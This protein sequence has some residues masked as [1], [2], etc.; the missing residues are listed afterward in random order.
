M[1]VFAHHTA[2]E[3]QERLQVERDRKAKQR[4]RAI[5]LALE[6][7]TSAAIGS[8]LG[9]RQPTVALWIRRYNE[10]GLSSLHDAVRPGRPMRLSSEQI[11]L[12]RLRLNAGP[13]PEDG[14]CTLRGLD[15]QRILEQEFGVVY[16]LNGV[17][18]LLHHLGYSSLMPRPQHCE[19]DLEAREHFKKSSSDCG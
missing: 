18:R 7:R 6:G 17:Y 15:L 19:T 5:L 2:L 8:R 12:F 16:S 11:A 14:I 9:V 4:L 13:K 1:T 10:I 3:L